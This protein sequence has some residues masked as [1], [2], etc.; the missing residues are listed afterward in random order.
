MFVAKTLSLFN[1]VSLEGELLVVDKP[2]S[3]F[4]DVNYEGKIINSELSCYGEKI[5]NKILVIPH[6]RGSTVGSY[7]LYSLAERKIGPKAILSLHPDTVVLVGCIISNIPY[8]YNVS[9]ELLNSSY[10]KKKASVNFIKRKACI[11]I[12][13]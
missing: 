11:E 7:I 13:D 2:L 6:G 3:F 10:N 1:G 9:R 4:G 5:A 8:A 12:L